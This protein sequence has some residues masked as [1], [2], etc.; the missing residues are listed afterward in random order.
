MSSVLPV[1]SGVP[2]GSVLGPTFFVLYMDDFG[3][4]FTHLSLKLS[5]DDAK[6]Y[7]LIFIH[8][9]QLILMKT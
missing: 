5:A 2:Q 8:S 1:S 4:D 3:N 9:N 6:L 7:M